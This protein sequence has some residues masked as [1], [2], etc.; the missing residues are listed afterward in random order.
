MD[1]SQ[2]G[3]F[4][5]G[6]NAHLSVLGPQVDPVV[7][8]LELETHSKSNWSAEDKVL[9]PIEESN[10]AIFER[11]WI[12]DLSWCELVFDPTF[13]S[14]SV[15]QIYGHVHNLVKS[16]H[17]GDLDADLLTP[18]FEEK[19]IVTDLQVDETNHDHGVGG[20]R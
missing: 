13:Q 11:L 5:L 14:V 7:E 8:I 18:A 2:N 16:N 19:V 20:L 12:D 6:A 17:D 4:Q 3:R 10:R 9:Y 1:K 15:L